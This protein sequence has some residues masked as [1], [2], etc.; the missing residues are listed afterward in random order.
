[1]SVF[2]MS[3]HYLY[4]CVFVDH[5]F[6]FKYVYLLNSQTGDE[7]VEAKKYVEAYA[8]SHGFEIKDYHVNNGIFRSA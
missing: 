8:E 3:Q 2:L 6:G 1:M 4:A 5:Y 7:A